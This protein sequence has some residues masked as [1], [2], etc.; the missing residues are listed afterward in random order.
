MTPAPATPE[1]AALTCPRRRNTYL[2]GTIHKRLQITAVRC[3]CW[4]VDGRQPPG[5]DQGILVFCLLA[6]SS[7]AYL[8]DMF[9]ARDTT[10][11]VLS[12]LP[13]TDADNDPLPFNDRY[14][15]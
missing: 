1:T 15:A 10:M 3:A 12:D 6:G 7:A 8:H 2:P 4:S 13:S 9:L 11:A 5:A 14:S